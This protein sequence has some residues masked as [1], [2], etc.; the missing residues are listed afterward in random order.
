MRAE[1]AATQREAVGGFR[2]SPQ[3]K[4]VWLA[5]QSDAALP[6]RASCALLLEGP[7][8]VEAL[9]AAAGRL[10]ELHTL[11]ASTPVQTPGRKFPLQVVNAR[12][13][14]WGDAVDL[15]GLDERA[16]AARVSGLLRE[17]ARGVAVEEEAPLRL[18]LVTLSA[19]RRLLLVSLNALLADAAT[20]QNLA[21]EVARV[22]AAAL[23][24]ESPSDEPVEYFA[25]SEWLNQLLDSEEADAGREFWRA[26][27]FS[28]ADALHLP[29]ARRDAARAHDFEPRTH[30]LRLSPRAAGAVESTARKYGATAEA[31]LL[32]CWAILLSRL[33]GQTSL[34]VGAV[35]GGRD[36]EELKE[37]LGPLEKTLPLSFSLDARWKFTRVLEEAQAHLAT[38]R[39]WQE[40]YVPEQTLART[41]GGEGA[42]FV[43]IHFEYREAPRTF[44]AGDVNFSVY[45]QHVYPERFKLKLS[46]LH[47]EGALNA[48]FHFDSAAHAEGDVER[49]GGQFVRLLESVS[50]DPRSLVGDLEILTEAEREQILFDFNRTAADYP[51][52]VAAH[53]LFERQA[54]LTPEAVALTFE[55]GSMT[56][57]ELNERANRLAR[58]L[59][60]LGAG[61]D[62]V[63]GILLGRCSGTIISLLAALKAGAAYLP[64]DPTYP[65]Q[66]LSFMLEDARPKVL[67]TEGRLRDMLSVPEGVTP[68]TVDEAAGGLSH[69]SPD[70]PRV[71]VDTNNLAYVIY[72]SGSTGTPKGVMVTHGGLANYLNWSSRA[73]PLREGCGAPVHSPLGFDLT[74]T[75]LWNP[76]VTGGRVDLLREGRGIEGLAE[77][78]LGGA[79]YGVVKITPAHLEA[80][81]HAAEEGEGAKR[82]RAH[83]FVIGGEAL[84]W[85]DVRYWRGRHPSVRLVNEYGPTET[86]VGCCVF[87]VSSD[88][89][90]A[91]GGVPIGRPIAN[92]QMYVLDEGLRPAPVGV[93]GELYIGGA[94]V[95]RGYLG[96]PAQTAERFVPDPYGGQAGARLY[97]T[98]DVGR[99][100]A[101]GVLEY[102]GREDQQVKVRGYRIELGE[103]E[104]A[105]RS[106][107]AVREAL[108]MARRS[109]A[110]ESQL[111]AYLV[112]EGE[113]ASALDSLRAHLAERLPEY[114]MPS[115]FVRL[116]ALPLSANGKLDRNALPAPEQAGLKS[117]TAYVAPRTPVEEE[118]AS[119]WKSLLRV[120]RVG[121]HDNFFELGGHSLLATQLALRA[122]E[123]FQVP[124]TMQAIFDGPTVAQLGAAVMEKLL[125]EEGGEDL[126]QMLEDLKQLSPEEVRALL[127]TEG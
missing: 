82:V 74:V 126:D 63:V 64:L 123:A 86:V 120:E 95:A 42:R 92:T 103:V 33:T 89:G 105:L 101:D 76:L 34:T 56:Y 88:E 97:R 25:V 83:S 110:G 31:L 16:R 111:V 23:R 78:V 47:G 72:T 79:D 109:P 2:L 45:E 28:G 41:G 11:L 70:N 90:E 14:A 18:R 99:Y 127:E 9:R 102:I 61:P 3:Q 26:Q 91:E 57:R 58:R 71:E 27:D 118:L 55:G 30:A 66:R 65:V 113:S 49:L 10:I 62:A 96:R 100:R 59:R 50:A 38:A 121:V 104:A 75:S 125:E 117:G 94:G 48:E 4:S 80:L 53:V 52:G 37:L 107:E 19:E 29:S 54:A 6:A 69:Y 81:R 8:D 13:P 44:A 124:V 114:M 46:C 85:E 112:G 36:E 84:G 106:H 122:Q 115:A 93:T 32:A 22:Y 67:L 15:S 43:P 20:F 87:E 116:E 1:E 40:C 35:S 60:A 12:P 24:G 17:E 7:L 108:V 5:R 73:Y 21:G 51:Q 39:Q 119:I 77:A 98:G 68:L